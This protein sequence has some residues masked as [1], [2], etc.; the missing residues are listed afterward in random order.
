[1]SAVSVHACPIAIA[2]WESELQE[3]SRSNPQVNVID[4]VSGIKALRNRVTMLQALRE[5]DI[6]LQVWCGLVLNLLRTTRKRSQLT[7]S[8][9]RS[10]PRLTRRRTPSPRCGPTVSR[11]RHR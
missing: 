5:Q 6:V 3:Y 9:Q 4:S 8:R 1:M 11:P 2:E 10:C 7:I